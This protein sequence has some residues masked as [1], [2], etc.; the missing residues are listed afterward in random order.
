MAI[1]FDAASSVLNQSDITSPYT[2]SWSHTCTGSNLVLVVA[3]HMSDPGDTIAG[4]TYNGVALTKIVEQANAGASLISLWYL[5]NP[6]TGANTITVTCD[7]SFSTC[8]GTAISL[9]GVAQTGTVENSG[10]TEADTANNIA[11]SVTTV[12]ANAWI[13]D[14][15]YKEATLD[16]MVVESGQTERVNVSGTLGD[17][18]MS[19]IA[20]VTPAPTSVGWNDNGSSFTFNWAH[21]A[22]SFAPAG[23]ATAVKDIIQQGVIAFSR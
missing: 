21:A 6:D 3:A 13:V 14:A 10:S 12:A 15:V 2:M 23:A 7:N 5:V 16:S 4:V 20:V 19:T 11:T 18:G 9:T 8:N 17:S 22:A 1:A